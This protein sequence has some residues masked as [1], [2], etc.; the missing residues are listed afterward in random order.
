MPETTTTTP[1]ATPKDAPMADAATAARSAASRVVRPLADR[2]ATDGMPGTRYFDPEEARGVRASSQQ[3][4]AHCRRVEAA[5]MALR[6]SYGVDPVKAST[7]RERVAELDSNA[8]AVRAPARIAV[9]HALD[10]AAQQAA[11]EALAAADVWA[12]AAAR[13]VAMCRLRDELGGRPRFDSLGGWVRAALPAPE[14]EHRPPRCRVVAD[15]HGRECAWTGGDG[16]ALAVDIHKAALL[17]DLK[18]AVGAPW[19]FE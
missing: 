1:T 4:A 5:T 9:L 11:R 15:P 17:S 12:T 10:V 18:K 19:P 13:Y 7:L 8:L 14:P 6:D 3:W 2:D 16:H